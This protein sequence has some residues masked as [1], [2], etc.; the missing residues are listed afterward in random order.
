MK[1][2]IEWEGRSIDLEWKEG[3]NIDNYPAWSQ[4]YGFCFT[5]EGKLLIV[6]DKYWILPGGAREEGEIPEETLRREVMEEANVILDTCAF[7]GVQKV[8]DPNNPQPR[9]YE[10]TPHFQIRYAAIIKEILPQQVDPA[11]G[12][13]YERMFI[14]P[15]AFSNYISWGKK[16]EMMCMAAQQW[17]NQY[18]NSAKRHQ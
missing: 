8:N 16:G 18:K 9:Q 14:D 5:E 17:F 13:M 2:T 6:K 11:S 7:I 4:A 15:K 12:N 10:T 1:E 3:G